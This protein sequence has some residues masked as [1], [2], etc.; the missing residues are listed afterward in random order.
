MENINKAYLKWSVTPKGFK[1]EIYKEG[2][3]IPVKKWETIFQ[4]LSKHELVAIQILNQLVDEDQAEV[5]ESNIILPYI[6]VAHLPDEERDTLGLPEPFPF[7]IEIRASGNLTDP[8]FRYIY[9]FLNGK[10]QPF[11]NPKRIGTYLEITP[12]QTYLLVSEVYHLIEALDEFNQKSPT[13]RDIKTNLLTFAKIKGLAQETA[14]ILDTYLNSE[15]VIAP[16]KITLR[17]KRIDKDVIEIEPVFCEETSDPDGNSALKPILRGHADKHF[18]KIFDRFPKERDIYAI[19]RGP[20]IVLTEQQK[21]ALGQVKRHKRV[22]GKKKE[23][24]LKN[25]TAFFDP[26]VIDFD[27]PLREEGERYLT[28]SDRVIGIGEYIPRILPIPPSPREIWLP[29]GEIIHTENEIGKKATLY[30]RPEEKP[31]F[32]QLVEQAVQA[33]KKQIKWKG[34]IIPISQKTLKSLEEVPPPSDKKKPKETPKDRREKKI[35]IIKD[36]FEEIDFSPEQRKRSGE[37]G[38]PA[39]I[40]PNVKLLDHQERGLKWLQV[41]WIR[42]YKGVLLADDMGL[43]KTLQA[44]GFMAWVQELMDN[45]QLPPKPM[46]IVAPVA[47]LENWKE[48]YRRFLEPIWGP[49]IEL[50]GAGLRQFKKRDLAGALSVKKE[51]EIK[52]KEDAEAI[53]F[54]SGRS[55]LLEIDKIPKKAV[56]ITT[57][58]TLRDYQFSFG[59]IDWAVIV[60]DEAQKIKTPTALVTT[61]V[62][63]MKYEFGIALTGTPVE[64]SWVDLWS[65]MDFV[66]PAHL[67]SLKE[68][69]AQYHNPLRK[70]ETNREALGQS[71]RNKVSPLLKRRMKEDHLKGLP[72]K[73]VCP[74]EIEMPQIQLE[75]YLGIIQKARESLPDPLSGQRKQHIF[76]VI[77]TLRDI[78]LHP[79]LPIFNEQ[80]LV[81]F[82]DEEIINAS[83]RLMKTTEILDK[84]CQK[85]EKAI[86]FLIS[87]KMQRVLQRLI[88]NRYGIYAHIINGEVT[89]GRRKSLIDAFQSTNGFN[90]IIMSPEAAGVGLNVTAA[91]HVIHLSRPWNPAKEDQ[92]TDRVYRIGQKRPVFV[93]VPLAVHPMFDNE[94]CKGTFDLKLHRLLEHKRQLSRSVLLPTV[95]EEKEWQTMGEEILSVTVEKRP[96]STLTI[97]DIDHMSAEMFEKAIASLYRK[98][99]Y[100]VELTPFSRDQGA[101]VV[102]LKHRQDG[103]SLLIQCKHTSNPNKA[104]NQKGIQEVL[105]ACGVY[106][107]E[108]N[109]KFKTIVITNAK[110]FTDQAMQ[111]AEANGVNLIPREKL[112]KLLKDYGVMLEEIL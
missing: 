76:S 18:L 71:L 75:H 92:A 39:A 40:R 38:F 15:E 19:P 74:Y 21:E 23:V 60:V 37:V 83:A 6:T 87:R 48:E 10:S 93:H 70:P 35:L 80:G 107:Q 27:T 43:G 49:F 72:E 112:A 28:W 96:T 16:S 20:R 55:L 64:N 77:G 99:G 22:S 58:E 68:F 12:E 41:L 59:L 7:D 95:I 34:E 14:A 1:F 25:P 101:D 90:V 17:L 86:V 54:S 110:R 97:T 100:Q 67:G 73:Y 94:I 65:I 82:S 29:E 102:A 52:D 24:L 57:Y 66:Q 13:Q 8:N 104:Q 32:K 36:L 53:I 3:I 11:V 88:K 105:A 84:I 106:Q 33:R 46:L 44:L 51:I 26:E 9:R 69:V 50:H 85:G 56:V 78:S 47:L 30:L 5:A 61:A 109:A 103:N 62:K 2:E 108:Y 98:M 111:I 63:A 4:K 79:Y 31:Q 89:G 81:D 45:G 91:N 42:G